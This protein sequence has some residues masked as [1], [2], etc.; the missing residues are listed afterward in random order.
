[1][2]PLST[3]ITAPAHPHYCHCPPALLPLPTRQR[4]LFGR[5]SGLVWKLL[6]QSFNCWLK[7][8]YISKEREKR[9]PMD[10][11]RQM[12]WEIF[13]QFFFLLFVWSFVNLIHMKENREWD[14]LIN[15]DSFL[16]NHL[17]WN[18]YSIK[19]LDYQ[20]S[21][22]PNREVIHSNSE[23]V[24]DLLFSRGRANLHLDL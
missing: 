20:L 8:Q 11:L 23:T 6:G 10:Q 18:S 4:L 17:I 24:W 19:F 21:E 7:V 22:K 15:I 2:M 13:W 5:V 9:L 1:M 3:P 16:L 14:M 12:Q